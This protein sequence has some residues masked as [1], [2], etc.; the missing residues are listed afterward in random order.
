[1][2]FKLLFPLD[3]GG[4]KIV[5]YKEHLFNK[6]NI[7]VFVFAFKSCCYVSEVTVIHGNR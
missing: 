5:K 2:F 1:M 3:R 7:S 4:K 6:N